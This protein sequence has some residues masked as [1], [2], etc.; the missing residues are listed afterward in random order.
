MASQT[1]S[2][3]KAGSPRIKVHIKGVFSTPATEVEALIDTGFTGFISMPMV[4]AFPLGL[5]LV[6]TSSFVLADNSTATNLLAFGLAWMGTETPQ[7]GLIVLQY[8]AGD[9]LLG[10]DFLRIMKKALAVAPLGGTVSLVDDAPPA[11]AAP[12]PQP[13]VAPAGKPAADP[14][15]AP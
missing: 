12:L 8:R 3:D 14:A 11:V 7:G 1:G 4:Q 9:V 10:M 13:A 2:L 6:G 15:R 5:P